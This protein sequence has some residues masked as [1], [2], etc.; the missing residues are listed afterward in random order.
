[1]VQIILSV[2]PLGLLRPQE[3][4]PW[5]WL[6]MEQ[7]SCSERPRA[8]EPDRTALE[9]QP[10][11]SAVPGVQHILER[12]DLLDA[13]TVDN[14]P[15]VSCSGLCGKCMLTSGYPQALESF[16]WPGV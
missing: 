15:L 5:A 16:L 2:L 3:L 8:E 12:L 13:F 14:L 1:M 6:T 4:N 7:H 9:T 10:G 11:T